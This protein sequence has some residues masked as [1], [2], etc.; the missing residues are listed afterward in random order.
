MDG[1]SVWWTTSRAWKRKQRSKAIPGGITTGRSG[2]ELLRP[3]FFE[4]FEF[5]LELET[6]GY[7][8]EAEALRRADS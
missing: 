6:G 7:A 4:E 1:P 3:L 2:D 8:P 5:F